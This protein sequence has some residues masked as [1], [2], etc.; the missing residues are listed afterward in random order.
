MEKN[1]TA[2]KLKVILRE[3]LQASLGAN[4]WC[5]SFQYDKFRKGK[6]LN[7]IALDARLSN[8]P[9]R[10]WNLTVSST[11]DCSQNYWCFG[12]SQCVAR[13]RNAHCIAMRCNPTAIGQAKKCRALICNMQNPSWFRKYEFIND[14]LYLG[15]KIVTDWRFDWPSETC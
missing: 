10:Q 7:G 9:I 1:I 5:I 11:V 15:S 14:C 6:K 2:I 8:C 13:R 3:R 12:A 4:I